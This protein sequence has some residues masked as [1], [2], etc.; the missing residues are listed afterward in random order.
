M[1]SK[2]S[3]KRQLRRMMKWKMKR[4]RIKAM[5]VKGLAM[6]R[7]KALRMI[8]ESMAKRKMSIG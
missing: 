1:T 5:G 7:L 4:W 2:R 6:D 8:R 3:P